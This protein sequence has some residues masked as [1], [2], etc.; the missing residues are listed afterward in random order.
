M[1]YTPALQRRRKQIESGGA[2][3]PALENIFVPLHFSA[4]PLQFEGARRTPE[5][6][7]RFITARQ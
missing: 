6:A 2:R 4:V 7:Q 1:D 5:W 3:I